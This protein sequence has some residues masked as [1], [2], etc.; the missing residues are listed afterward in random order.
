MPGHES[1]RAAAARD[2]SFVGLDIAAMAHLIHQMTGAAGAISG[3]LRTNGA[4]P[5]SVPRTGIRQAAAVDTWTR[6][7]SGMLTRRRN[8]AITH[9]DQGGTPMPHVSPGRLGKQRRTTAR[10]AGR[11]IGHFPDVRAAL[12]AGTADASAVRRALDDHRP[13][14]EQVWRHLQKNADD[15]DYTHGFYARLGPARTAG[16]IKTATEEQRH[17]IRVSLGVASHHLAMNEKWFRDLLDEALR[18]HVTDDTVRLLA[19]ADLSRGARVALAH[20]GLMQFV[21]EQ[22]HGRPPHTMMIGPA[23]D[24]PHASV[25]LYS[26]HPDALHRALERSPHDGTLRRL[27]EHATT[28]RDADPAA[29][30]AN[31]E[32]LAEFRA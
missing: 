4:L 14:P 21:E 16:L 25:E 13:V 23:A 7:Q 5:P 11:D 27:V 28:A 9:L 19:A 32:R 24:D 6:G 2:K 1:L 22:R 3:W 8:Y 29:V 20:V 15:P 18:E 12:K 26:R 10:G 30:R 31:A 17:D